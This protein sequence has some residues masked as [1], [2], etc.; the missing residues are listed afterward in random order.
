MTSNGSPTAVWLRSARSPGQ[1]QLGP[2]RGIFRRAPQTRD[3]VPVRVQSAWNG[4]RT[5]RISP[6]A[7]ARIR[8]GRAEV[9]TLRPSHSVAAAQVS[10][11]THL[12]RIRAFTSRAGTRPQ[13]D[14]GKAPGNLPLRCRK[15]H[16]HKQRYFHAGHRRPSPAI[17]WHYAARKNTLPRNLGP[18]RVRTPSAARSAAAARSRT[19]RRPPARAAGLA[20]RPAVR[21]RR[22]GL[23][24]ASRE[25]R[26]YPPRPGSGAHHTAPCCGRR[27]AA[28]LATMASATLRGPFADACDDPR[29]VGR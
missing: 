26:Q 25:L 18:G 8:S 1:Q 12:G 19:G 11:Q 17:K 4:A 3:R 6:H 28:M 9:Q 5:R 23:A 22:H 24:A 14:P 27:C 2:R 29:R 21:G 10:Q 13:R 16:Q 20:A 15:M 7:P